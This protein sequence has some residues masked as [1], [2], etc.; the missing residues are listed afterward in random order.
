[1]ILN[2][3]TV[4]YTNSTNT[5]SIYIPVQLCAIWYDILQEVHNLARTY[6]S[7][8]SLLLSAEVL[9]IIGPRSI[10]VTLALSFPKYS[11]IFA[12]TSTPPHPPPITTILINS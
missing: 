10:I 4:V 7:A 5:T 12:A 8:I 2:R 9:I 11:A 6:L 1:M 3:T